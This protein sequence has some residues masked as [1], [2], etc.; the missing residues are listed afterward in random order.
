MASFDEIIEQKEKKPQ[1]L[2]SYGIAKCDYCGS[3]HGIY[4]CENGH[5]TM[6][7][8][9]CLSDTI[10]IGNSVKFKVRCLKPDCN[11]YLLSEGTAS[12]PFS[13]V[14]NSLLMLLIMSHKVF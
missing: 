5:E 7:C 6:F 12:M 10:K 14:V 9:K 2:K 13:L 3:T 1:K 11:F 4:R 8:K